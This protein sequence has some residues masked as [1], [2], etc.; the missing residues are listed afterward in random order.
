M[1]KITKLLCL[2][3]SMLLLISTTGCGEEK[4]PTVVEKEKYDYKGIHTFEATETN[5]FLVK[6]GKTDY[7]LVYPANVLDPYNYIGIARREFRTFFEKATGITVIQIPD[8]GLTYNE[9]ARYISLGDNEYTRSAGI[10]VKAIDLNTEGVRIESKGKSIFLYGNTTVGSLYAVY[11]FMQYEFNY[12]FFYN[13]CYEIDSGVKNVSFKNYNITD[14]PDIQQRTCAMMF[15]ERYGTV[16]RRGEDDELAPYRTRTPMNSIKDY[17]LPIHQVIGDPNSR[18]SEYHNTSEIWPQEVYGVEHP[19]WYATSGIQP[20]FTCDGDEEELKAMKQVALEK[21]AYALQVYTPE[22]YP[23][24]NTVTITI[25]DAGGRCQ[26]PTCVEMAKKY[27]DQ[28]GLYEKDCE[29]AVVLMFVNDVAELVDEWMARP[30]NA[31]YKRDLDYLFFA[32]DCYL[33]CPAKFNETTG[34]YEPIDEAVR[35]RDNVGVWYCHIEPQDYESM[36]ADTELAKLGKK[37][38]QAWG[39]IC[40]VVWGYGYDTYADLYFSF[41]DTFAAYNDESFQWYSGNNMIGLIICTQGSN[42]KNSSAFYTL[43][44]Y[45]S[46]KLSWQANLDMNE[47]VMDFFKAM[48]KD[49]WQ[50]MYQMFEDIRIYNKEQIATNP[51]FTHNKSASWPQ[52]LLEKYRNL[53]DQAKAKIEKYKETDI[54]LYNATRDHIDIEWT[55]PAYGL[56]TWYSSQYSEEELNAIKKNFKFA[57]TRNGITNVGQY[58]VG[59]DQMVEDYPD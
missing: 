6:D 29:S 4:K 35:P 12:K 41:Y 9:N 18:R 51:N 8:T 25:E 11:D 31:K 23:Y 49:G 24:Y 45:L 42:G 33:D 40:K 44:A 46:Y 37:R 53:C 56:L 38:M 3:L 58:I 21:I 52:N 57:I 26:C 22:E 43:K 59:L 48:Y 5:D 32:Y 39:D 54:E 30:E 47:L 28:C 20:C 34:K 36:F 2:I 55:F 50:E 19:K 10:D 14:I 13:D 7:V 17:V 1:K 27:K 16:A 15:S